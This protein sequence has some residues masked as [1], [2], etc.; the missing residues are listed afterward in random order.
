MKNVF[1]CLLS[2]LLLSVNVAVMAVEQNA[3][4][5]S[6]VQAGAEAKT[7][8]GT[9]LTSISPVRDSGAVV[10]MFLGLFAVLLLIFALAW[11]VRKV[12]QGGLLSNPHLKILAS[13][14]LGPRERLIVVAA[15]TQQL[16]IG[17]APGRISTL[18]VFD[19]PL[20]DTNEV[21]VSSEFAKKIQAV[22]QKSSLMAASPNANVDKVQD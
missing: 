21:P 22:M 10:K 12:G 11:L 18:H 15:G 13:L 9:S 5:A 4:A 19:E 6:V 17:V 1:L 20:I 16:L 2:M 14:P 8:A 3:A 7:T